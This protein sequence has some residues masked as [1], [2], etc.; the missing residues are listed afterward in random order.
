MNQMNNCPGWRAE[1]VSGEAG[2][3]DLCVCEREREACAAGF[4]ESAFSKSFQ[5]KIS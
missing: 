1:W 5:L 2:K 4:G 3:L